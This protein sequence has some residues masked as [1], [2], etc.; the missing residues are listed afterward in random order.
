MHP[1][2]KKILGIIIYEKFDGEMAEYR[3][4]EINGATEIETFIPLPLSLFQSI[5]LRF[6]INHSTPNNAI[7]TER[8]TGRF[9]NSNSLVVVCSSDFIDAR[10]AISFVSRSNCVGS[11]YS[12]PERA[13]IC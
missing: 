1:R 11:A 6:L 4:Q 9:H 7:T 3:I 12:P 13:E 10:E 8:S 5:P 2:R